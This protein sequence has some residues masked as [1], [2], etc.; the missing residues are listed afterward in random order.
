[1][2]LLLYDRRSFSIHGVS[3]M[4]FQGQD[5]IQKEW[6]L[7]VAVSLSIYY[8]LSEQY[9]VYF[10]PFGKYDHCIS[11]INGSSAMFNPHCGNAS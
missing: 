9:G 5:I 6:K 3:C 1:M 4:P 2:L 11:F 7:V 8:P 10:S